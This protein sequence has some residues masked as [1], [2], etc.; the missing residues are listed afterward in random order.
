[1]QELYKNKIWLRQKYIDGEY[2][3]RTIAKLCGVCY[4]TIQYWLK[5]FDISKCHRMGNIM[6]NNTYRNKDWLCQKYENEELSTLAI[7][8]LCSVDDGTIWQ[9]LKR[10]NIPRRTI[11]DAEKLY[12]LKN[13]GI[14]KG[15][16]DP[17]WKG[18]RLIKNGYIQILK[19]DHPYA[20]NC[21][22]IYE[23]RLIMEKKLGR[24]LTKDEIVHHINGIRDDN[25][26]EN[27]VIE[28]RETHQTGYIGGYQVGTTTG[29]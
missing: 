28:D 14:Q 22:Y 19:S 5:K 25:R 26:P 21:G 9:W 7:A 20:N 29:Y 18:G 23:H 10:F 24:Y 13:P 12:Y 4:G 17:N 27:L 8:K 2:S 3:I 16:N 11:G 6:A 15:E 1:M